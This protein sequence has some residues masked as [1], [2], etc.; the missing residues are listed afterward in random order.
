MDDRKQDLANGLAGRYAIEREL[1][2]GGMA[3]VW[4]ARDLRYDRL[5][6]LKVL[7][8]ELAVSLGAERFLREIMLAARLQ[9]PHVVSVYE[10]GEIETAGHPGAPVLWFAMPYVEGES[11]RERL[12]RQGRLPR[13]EALRIAREAA[14]GLHY[15]HEH[16]VIHRDVKPENILLTRDGSTLVADFGIARP[17]GSTSASHLTGT[18]IV[19]GTPAYMSPEQALGAELDARTDIYSLGCV[20]YEML[21]GEPPHTGLTMHAI[22]A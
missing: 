11:L 6:A 16:G 3:T 15:A 19:V 2:H 18:G 20:L 8:P 21:T 1:G 12:R 13:R 17:T 22:V 4:L 10:S 14:R 7:R 5:V 9:H